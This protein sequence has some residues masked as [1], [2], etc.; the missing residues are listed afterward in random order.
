MHFDMYSQTKMLGQPGITYCENWP[1][2]RLPIILI[3]KKTSATQHR[4]NARACNP[5][6]RPVTQ[7]RSTDPIAST[8]Y[9]I[10]IVLSITNLK[11]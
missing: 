7:I 3:D 11:L 6:L 1:E 2:L 10:M 9:K 8:K 5:T 4:L